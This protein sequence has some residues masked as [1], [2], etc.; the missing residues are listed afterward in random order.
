MGRS[1]TVSRSVVRKTMLTVLALAVAVIGILAL[2]PAA[3]AQTV[4]G[5]EGE[6]FFDPYGDEVC[7]SDEIRDPKTEVEAELLER[8]STSPAPSDSPLPFTGADVT[9]FLV[10]GAAL[11]GTGGFM[12]RRNKTRR[13]EI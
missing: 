11:I 9:L 10:T 8:P 13:S 6:C 4:V 12:V 3:S 2:S 7:P 5:G 1:T